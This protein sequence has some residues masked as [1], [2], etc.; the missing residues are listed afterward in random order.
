[1][2]KKHLEGEG[3]SEYCLEGVWKVFVKCLEGI[4]LGQIK[5]E[6]V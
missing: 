2:S 6:Q 5:T 1:M 4:K 3:V